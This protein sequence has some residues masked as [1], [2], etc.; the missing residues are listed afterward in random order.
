MEGRHP[1]R[2]ADPLT[3]SQMAGCG[4]RATTFRMTLGSA[5]AIITAALLVSTLILVTASVSGVG[6]A[7]AQAAKCKWAHKA[8]R[9]VT[10]KHA[11]RAVLCQI[12]R[13]RRS[14]GLKPVRPRKSLRKAGKRHSRYMQRHNCFAHQCPGEKDLVGRIHSTSYLP[15]NCSWRVGETLAWGTKRRGTPRAIVKAWMHSPPHR[16]VLLDGRLRN[17]GV[18]LVWGSPSNRR[19]KAATYTADFGYKR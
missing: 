14:H 8:P 5:V 13:K 10:P 17:V 18:G 3:R 4:G 11:R 19:A 7:S 12:N 9:H 15:C 6:V 16:H 2:Q 1:R